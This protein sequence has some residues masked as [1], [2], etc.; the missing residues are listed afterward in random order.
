LVLALVLAAAVVAAPASPSPLPTNPF[1]LNPLPRSSSLPV[2]GTTRTRPV[3]TAIHQA[4]KP[5]LEAAMK[6]DTIY[7]SVRK[8][9]F[10]YVALDSGD[11]R[12]L[13]IVQMD[14]QIAELVRSTSALEDALKSPAFRPAPNVRPE[15]VKTL[16]D[17]QSSLG[18]VLAAQRIQLDALSGFVETERSGMFGKLDESQQQAQS[19]VAPTG[20][21]G[22]T[23][24]PVT[25]FLPDSPQTLVPQHPTPQGLSGAHML[26]RDLGDISA[27]TTKREQTAVHVIVEA[28][29]QCR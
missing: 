18:G 9:I 22:S 27:A 26:D 14:K 3:C 21:V 13:R 17:L 4:V 24:S 6:N 28:A 16:H 7:T 2:I 1:N 12:N 25:G 10:N 5:A 29:G 15:D 23:P 11:A 8:T 19:A 20:Q